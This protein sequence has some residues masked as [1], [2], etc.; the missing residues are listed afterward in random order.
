LQKILQKKK[1]Y[2]SRTN[3]LLIMPPFRNKD[4]SLTKTVLSKIKLARFQKGYSQQN[5]ASEL[6]ISQNAYHKIENGETKL[7]LEHFLNI[8]SILDEKPHTFFD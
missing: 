5:I 3:K 4:A 1:Q 6:D 8:C 2:F 7:T